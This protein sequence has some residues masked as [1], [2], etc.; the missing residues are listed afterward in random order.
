MINID[1]Y[2]NYEDENKLKIYDEYIKEYDEKINMIIEEALKLN[3]IKLSNVYIGIGVV[4]PDRIRELNKEFR[5]VDRATDV[6]SFPMFSREELA[7]GINE[8]EENEEVSIGDIVLC[9]EVIENQ[10]IEYGTGFNR[11]MLYMITHG[12]CHLLGY[13][14]IEPNEKKEM[15]EMEE[16]ILS[17]IGEM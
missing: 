17:R 9:L 1:F 15:R 4:T 8:L 5:N 10:A 16:K 14:H 6:L 2:T 13:D 12:I 7:S 11:E 3:N